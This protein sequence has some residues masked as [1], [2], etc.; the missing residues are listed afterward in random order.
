ME[1]Q[2]ARHNAIATFIDEQVQQVIGNVFLALRTKCSTRPPS[3][4]R[5]SSYHRRRS[6]R[7]PTARCSLPS[8]D[9][10]FIHH[11]TLDATTSSRRSDLRRMSGVQYSFSLY[12]QSWSR[13]SRAQR[14]SSTGIQQYTDELADDCIENA[15]HQVITS[16]CRCQTQRMPLD[17]S[18]ETASQ[19]RN[20]TNHRCICRSMGPINDRPVHRTAILYPSDREHRVECTI[21]VGRQASILRAFQE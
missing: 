8:N 16:V 14:S 4:L 20:S 12:D 3:R 2:T 7:R 5:S 17:L 19:R 18:T 1:R 10:D 21:N 13:K 11:S 6:L 9:I 15:L